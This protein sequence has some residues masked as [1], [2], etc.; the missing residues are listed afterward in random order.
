[1][2]TFK[3]L[4]WLFILSIVVCTLPFNQKMPWKVIYHLL[5]LPLPN[6]SEHKICQVSCLVPSKE[7]KLSFYAHHSPFPASFCG[8]T[9]YSCRLFFKP[10]SLLKLP[11]QSSH[12]YNSP[13]QGDKGNHVSINTKRPGVTPFLN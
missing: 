13:L 2:F 7:M 9:V 4:V 1:M 6:V 12:P 10:F 3:V 5:L 8:C 11:Q